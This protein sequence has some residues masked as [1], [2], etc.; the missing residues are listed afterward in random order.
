M[1]LGTDTGCT[2]VTGVVRVQLGVCAQQGNLLDTS[3]DQ[4]Y[5]LYYVEPTGIYSTLRVVYYSDSAC[6]VP[7]R[8]SQPRRVA[9][10]TGG[11][12]H[13][14][15]DADL[16]IA[17]V[18]LSRGAN[19][20][21]NSGLHEPGLQLPAPLPKYATVTFASSPDAIPA[22]SSVSATWKALAIYANAVSCARAGLTTNWPVL[23]V[24][25]PVAVMDT[26]TANVQCTD[27]GLTSDSQYRSFSDW[28]SSWAE[29]CVT[30]TP[31][32]SGYMMVTLWT[33]DPQQV[34][35][36]PSHSHSATHT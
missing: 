20:D 4:E 23:F 33:G 1:L 36:K 7:V 35:F 25:T 5:A 3:Y 21:L 29:G 22:V 19:D 8:E 28:G 6:T 10:F 14:N 27:I 12:G 9:Y 17:G 26:C 18:S 11:C 2:P 16:T 31:Q 13:L 24:A 15:V 32:T 30:V 34:A